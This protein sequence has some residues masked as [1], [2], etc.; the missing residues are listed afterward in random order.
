MA[1]N[2]G[3][4]ARKKSGFELRHNHRYVWVDT[5]TNLFCWC[6]GHVKNNKQYRSLDIKTCVEF[7][8]A[9]YREQRAGSDD[10]AFASRVLR[11]FRLVLVQGVSRHRNIF[12][13]PMVAEFLVGNAVQRAPKKPSPQEMRMVVGEDTDLGVEEKASRNTAETIEILIDG[14]DATKICEVFIAYITELIND[15]F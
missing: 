6:H 8:E 1:L 9:V 2:W 5:D 3:T 4:S 7:V 11:G 10:M 14:D 12:G 13:R 15:S